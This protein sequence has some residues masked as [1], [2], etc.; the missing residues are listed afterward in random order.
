MSHGVV[1]RRELGPAEGERSRAAARA[2]NAATKGQN[3]ER[4]GRAVSAAFFLLFRRAGL[5]PWQQ[6]LAQLFQ[7]FIVLGCGRLDGGFDFHQLLVGCPQ[8]DVAVLM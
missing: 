4:E 8:L 7:K 3:G 6:R 5:N 1:A 2:R